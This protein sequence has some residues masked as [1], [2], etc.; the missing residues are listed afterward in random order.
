MKSLGKSKL[1]GSD[2]CL[3]KGVKETLKVKDGDWVEFF[4]ENGK[5]IIQKG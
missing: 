3:T 2:V 1:K 5:I 4:E